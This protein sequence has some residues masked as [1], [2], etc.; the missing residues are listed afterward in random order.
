MLAFA[1]LVREKSY[2]SLN[3]HFFVQLKKSLKLKNIFNHLC[4]FCLFNKLL[5]YILQGLTDF[6][7]R[8]WLPYMLLKLRTQVAKMSLPILQTFLLTFSMPATKFFSIWKKYLVK[9]NFQLFWDVYLRRTYKKGHSE[10]MRKKPGRNYL[11]WEWVIELPILLFLKF[12][13]YF[14]LSQIVRDKGWNSTVLLS[15][16]AVHL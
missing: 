13:L 16:P 7:C 9:R 12:W 11:K 2:Y 5:D 3:L 14:D 8:Y 1:K 15:V 4:S 10:K 6:F